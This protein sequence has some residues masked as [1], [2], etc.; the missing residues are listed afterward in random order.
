MEQPYAAP[1]ANL[2]QADDDLNTYK[3]KMWAL[4]GRIGRVQ[5]L[6]YSFVVSLLLIFVLS[7]LTAVLSPMFVQPETGF[8]VTG[9][10]FYLLMFAVGFVYARRRLHDLGKS[11]WLSLLILLP[12]VNL[13][14]GLYLLFAPGEDYPNDFGPKPVAGSVL[15]LVIGVIAP[16]FLIGILAAIAIP[17]YHDF[18]SRAKARAV[19]LEKKPAE[20]TAEQLENSPAGEESPTKN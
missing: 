14:F 9:I 6:A 16:I 18:T 12:L 20:N 13:I 10:A 8:F 19:Q 3:P 4:N 17:A 2:E 5:Y 7:I 15:I 11:G 1:R